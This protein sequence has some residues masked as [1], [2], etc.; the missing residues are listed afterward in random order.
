MAD[1]DV[2]WQQL[3]CTELSAYENI[4]YHQYAEELKVLSEQFSNIFC[5]FKK[6][7]DFFNLFA[8]LTKRIVQNDPLHLKMEL[9]EI[10]ENS[11]LKTSSCAISTKLTSKKTIF[12][13]SE[14][15]QED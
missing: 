4:A 2:G 8:S 9:I 14:N 6:C 5:D 15:P 13:N 1:T 12:L 7:D 10:Q 11:N 3:L